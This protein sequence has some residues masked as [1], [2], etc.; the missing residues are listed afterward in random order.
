VS[1][2]PGYSTKP[3]PWEN[4]NKYVRQMVQAMGARRCFWGTDITRLIETKGLTYQDTIEHFT[5]DMG[6]DADQL[7]W[8]M[9]RG[10]CEC[11]DWPVPEAHRS[12]DMGSAGSRAAAHR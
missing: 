3:A 7:D 10:I 12:N 9:G 8:I 6:F 11:L 4:V 1:S 5:R 2:I